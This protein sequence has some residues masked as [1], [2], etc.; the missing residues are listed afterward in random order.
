MEEKGRGEKRSQHL[1]YVKEKEGGW[2]LKKERVPGPHQRRHVEIVCVLVDSRG[3]KKKYLRGRRETFRK[4]PFR[5]GGE[6]T[7][8]TP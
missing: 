1:F 2:G 3:R 7:K 5:R 6:P 8:A 4:S